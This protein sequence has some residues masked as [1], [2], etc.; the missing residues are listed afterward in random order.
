MASILPKIPPDAQIAEFWNWFQ[1]VANDLA[2]A[3][4]D[5]KSLLAE[6]EMRVLEMGDVAWEL[7]PGL[8]EKHALIISPDGAKE[9]LPVTE[10]IVDQAPSIP[11]WEFQSARPPRDWDMRFSIEGSNGRHLEI[12]ARPWRYVL[13]KYPDNTFDIVVEQNN[14][15]LVSEDER[16]TAAVVFLDGTIG[17][18]KRVALLADIEPVETFSAEHAQ[19]ANPM[20]QLVQHLEFLNSKQ[21]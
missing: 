7:G 10:H 9:W 12:D 21:S 8:L 11:D 19:K 20:H 5:D 17:E 6:L 3:K 4:F 13:F 2:Q 1:S 15:Q 18:R 14:L 16:Y